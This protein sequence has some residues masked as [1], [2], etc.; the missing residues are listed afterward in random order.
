MPVWYVSTGKCSWCAPA[1]ISIGGGDDRA[2]E[3]AVEDAQLG[4]HDRGGALDLREGDDLARLEA[5]ARD[6]EVLDGALRL[7]AVQGAARDAHL[8]HRVVL[9]PVLRLGGLAHGDLVLL[10]EGFGGRRAGQIWPTTMSGTARPSSR[11]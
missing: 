1:M 5:R 10:V 4:V 11:R 8:A 7:R 3:V 2:R 6:G 9:D